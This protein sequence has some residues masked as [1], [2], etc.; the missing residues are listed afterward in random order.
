MGLLDVLGLPPPRAAVAAPDDRLKRQI[1]GAAPLA[2]GLRDPAARA[3]AVA[4]LKALDEDRRRALALSDAGSQTKALAVAQRRL[5][6]LV[7]GWRAPPAAVPEVPP[8]TRTVRYRIEEPMRGTSREVELPWAPGMKDRFELEGMPRGRFAVRI[9]AP[10]QAPLPEAADPPPPRPA[11]PVPTPRPV[12]PVRPVPPIPKPQPRPVPPIPEPQPAPPEPPKPDE[13]EERRKRRHKALQDIEDLRKRDADEDSVFVQYMKKDFVDVT[14]TEGMENVSTFTG[15][16]GTGAKM[17]P[18]GQGLAAGMELT[19]LVAD[20][21]NVTYVV[22]KSLLNDSAGGSGGTITR[23]AIEK[24][25]PKLLE[26]AKKQIVAKIVKKH[27]G[28]PKPMVEKV[29][30][31]AI[32]RVL[33]AVG[34]AAG[35]G[36]KDAID[37]PTTLPR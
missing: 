31:E 5:A 32:E 17:V 16:M 21:A 1:R 23:K 11:P 8:A 19:G 6:I 37:G 20:V 24:G 13:E 3:A 10:E 27:P 35:D 25:G 14:L 30:D 12:P 29:V 2:A 26:A 15:W 9:G 33:G 36:V 18:G 7:D 28:I 34:D 4:A 22:T